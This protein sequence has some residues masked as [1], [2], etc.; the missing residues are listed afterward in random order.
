MT[1]YVI[2]SC[3]S[4][5]KTLQRLSIWFRIKVIGFTK[6]YRAHYLSK[7]IAC[8]FISL[9]TISQPPWAPFYSLK[10]L[11]KLL[12]Q[13]LCTCSLSLE[14]CA[15]LT[16]FKWNDTFSVRLFSVTALF[17]VV[18]LPF[19]FF[20]CFLHSTC[21]HLTYKEKVFYVLQVWLCKLV[22]PKTH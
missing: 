16:A 17:K 1:L 19:T 13:A 6:T 2:R 7:S 3:R 10:I 11:G 14:I 20:L 15:W 18:K 4:S 8:D 21:H 22:W 9:F 12:P 5:S